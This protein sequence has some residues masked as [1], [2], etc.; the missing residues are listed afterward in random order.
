M[1]D[2]IT[3][4][5][6]SGRDGAALVGCLAR[7]P[8]AV[9][10]LRARPDHA[11]SRD[12]CQQIGAQLSLA[13][14]DSAV[15]A[16]VIAP[17]FQIFSSGTHAQG[18]PCAHDLAAL[19]DL[20]A[21]VA[22]ATK[23]VVAALLGECFGSRL[24][25]A[26]A[27]HGRIGAPDAV[28]AFDDIS[29]SAMPVG[30][31]AVRL[32]QLVG[33]RAALDML[34]GAAQ[35]RAGD[36]RAL[37]LLDDLAPHAQLI[38]AGCDL[39]QALSRNFV[40]AR[41]SLTK[42]AQ[43]DL[44]DIAR[45]RAK[46]TAQDAGFK[47]VRDALITAVESVYLL[48]PA[49]ALQADL[50]AAQHLRAAPQ[51]RALAYAHYAAG[52]FNAVPNGQISAPDS[53]PLPPDRALLTLDL[54]RKMG[55]VVTYFEARG[56]LRTDILGAVAAYGV[57]VPDGVPLPPCPKGAQDVMP[58]L[59]AV[60]ANLGVQMLRLGVISN[61]AQLDGAVLAA[62][63]FPRGKGGPMYQADLCGALVMRA[64]LVQRSGR[65]GGDF[66]A[67]DPMWDDLISRGRGVI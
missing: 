50:A 35:V 55:Q 23:P 2:Q 39:A 36:A 44:A 37:G 42:T 49:R 52:L 51:A 34:L 11:I 60:W 61:G 67:P 12:L 38:E 13:L 45:A 26:L 30:G 28:C 29:F 57:A 17:D 19:D 15:Q 48:P 8:V 43:A 6:N 47:A 20:C 24:S 16:V 53:R 66:F 22:G 18:R 46:N 63:M 58:A 1:T 59:L 31:G 64:Q 7:P 21:Q 9:L 65:D 56:L 27:C 3:Q 14:A 5:E 33:A 54:R 62:N 41:R 40:P 32:A 10:R 25:L 4:L